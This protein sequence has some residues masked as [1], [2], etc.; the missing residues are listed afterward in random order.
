[1]MSASFVWSTVVAAHRTSP[2]MAFGVGVCASHL[3]GTIGTI[4][5]LEFLFFSFPSLRISSRISNKSR[6]GRPML[7][8]E[9]QSDKWQYWRWAIATQILVVLLAFTS[10]DLLTLRVDLRTDSNTIISPIQVALNLVSLSLASD[11]GLYWAHRLL[12]S[13]WLWRTVHSIHHRVR[14]PTASSVLYIHPIDTIMQQGIPMTM[15][16]LL[17]SPDLASYYIFLVFHLTETTCFHSG[18]RENILTQ[19]LFFHWLPGRASIEHHD[20]HH[21]YSGHAGHVN[22]LGEGFWIWDQIFRT[23]LNIKNKFLVSTKMK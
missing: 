17:V 21:W 13:D 9:F 15:A 20:Q 23:R 14:E 4:L 1:M 16:I 12:H 22:N 2:R 8:P 6:N 5:L 18:L 10:S 19:I 7:P 3:I 11:F